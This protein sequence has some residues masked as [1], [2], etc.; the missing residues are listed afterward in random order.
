MAQLVK[1]MRDGEATVSGLGAAI[2]VSLGSL[3]GGYLGAKFF[4]V[5][6]RKSLKA[7]KFKDQY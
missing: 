7:W 6:Y 1:M 2:L 5:V 3:L 4:Y